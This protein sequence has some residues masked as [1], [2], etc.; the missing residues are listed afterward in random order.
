MCVHVKNINKYIL[1]EYILHVQ[2]KRLA[3]TWFFEDVFSV[4]KIFI[5]KN[6]YII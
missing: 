4:L 2:M 6:R 3:V 1:H 5:Y